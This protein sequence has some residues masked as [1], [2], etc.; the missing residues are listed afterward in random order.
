[1]T[2]VI[3][4][5]S[6]NGLWSGEEKAVR[7]LDMAVASIDDEFNAGGVPEYGDLHVQFDT[8]TWNVDEDG[9]I[10]TDKR[11]IKELR[12][13]MDAHGLP[14]KDVSYSEQGR[15]GDDFVSLDV[16]EKFLRAWGEK[17]NVNWDA[18]ARKQQADFDARWGR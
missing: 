11:W 6:G 2:A 5:T 4:N 3:F 1:M 12:E 15:Q 7:I 14:G 8:K 9:L 18:A 16:G 17:F 13:F 10:Y